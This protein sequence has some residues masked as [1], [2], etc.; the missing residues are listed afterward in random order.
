MAT[1]I[2]LALVLGAALAPSAFAQGGSPPSSPPRVAND[3]CRADQAPTPVVLVHGT[4]AN[5]GEFFKLTPRLETAGYCVYALNFGCTDNSGSCGRARIEASARELKAFIDTRALPQSRSGKVS[6]VGHS[7]GG[8]LPRYYINYLGGQSKVTDM[9][10]FSA[11]N[12]G[13]D[14]PL[15]PFAQN[16]PACRQQAPYRSAF[17]EG[18]NAG[19]ETRGSIAYTQVQTRYD[20]VVFPYFSAFLADTSGPSSNGPRTLPLNGPRT[21]NYCLQDQF[22]TN[23]ADHLNIVFDDQAY[24]P[25]FDAL[26]RSGP[27]R[28]PTRPD[29]VCARLAGDAGGGGSG[30]GGSGG[31]PACTI[32]GSEDDDVL[33]GTAREDVICAGAGNDVVRGAGA[34][35]QV[36]G[37]EGNDTLR[38]D[39]DA[40]DLFGE[41]GRDV[42]TSSDDVRGNDSINGGADRDVCNGDFGDGQANCP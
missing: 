21:T 42:I 19:D 30:S 3:R 20:E 40:D 2:A 12:H 7:Q 1:V 24:V 18:I 8:L 29:S 27:A 11:S 26:R 6:I 35:D 9:I 13:T 32:R 14:N 31:R 4:F 33:I 10:S 36:Y 5:R 16:C 15:A 38:G 17:T 23:T 28:P 22:P 34:D 37:G 25:V 41:G 39:A